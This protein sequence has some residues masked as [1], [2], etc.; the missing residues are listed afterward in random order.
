MTVILKRSSKKTHFNR[1][2]FHQTK[3]NF[4]GLKFVLL[5]YATIVNAKPTQKSTP[6]PATERQLLIANL[7]EKSLILTIKWS[8]D[9]KKIVKLQ[10][11]GEMVEDCIYKG[12]FIEDHYR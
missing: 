10:N 1:F 6:K 11:I 4:L 8:D 5:I 12:S 3:M 7:E 9:A 2:E